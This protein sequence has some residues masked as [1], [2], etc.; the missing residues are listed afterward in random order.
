M[1][2]SPGQAWETLGISTMK[3]LGTRDVQAMKGKNVQIWTGKIKSLQTSQGTRLKN[4]FGVLA[5]P[6]PPTLSNY[7]EG[8]WIEPV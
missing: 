5:P 3:L 2:S 4:W 6:S 8:E 7:P 1:A